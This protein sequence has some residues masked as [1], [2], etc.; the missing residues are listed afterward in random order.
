MGDSTFLNAT[1]IAH[2]HS[3]EEGIK[4]LTDFY[5]RMNETHSELKLI[6]NKN[7]PITPDLVDRINSELYR[8]KTD[9]DA[10]VDTYISRSQYLKAK[11]EAQGLAERL[12]DSPKLLE[13]QLDLQ[14]K[15]ENSVGIK[16]TLIYLQKE[17]IDNWVTRTNELVKR[18]KEPSKPQIYKLDEVLQK[19]S[20]SEPGPMFG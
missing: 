3:Q 7:I 13:A 5:K 12:K 8:L 10:L 2:E 19:Y 17:L 6:E 14:K 9:M 18:S 1:E 20:P 4:S 16:I 11:S 15:L